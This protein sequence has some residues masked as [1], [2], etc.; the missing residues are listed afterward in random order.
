M[1]TDHGFIIYIKTDD[2][3]KDIAEDLETKFDPSKY[4]LY[5][6]LPKGKNQE[7]IGLM[8]DEL[9]RKIMKEFVRVRG[10][11]YSYLTDNNDKDKTAKSTEKFYQYFF[12]SII[13]YIHNIIFIYKISSPE[14][15]IG[16]GILPF[17][18][19]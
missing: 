7:I 8:K 10:K 6:P 13:I 16:E 5:R 12:F 3:Y 2:I 9:G 1:D 14:C 15:L 11:T 18:Q 4:K 19:S 17:N